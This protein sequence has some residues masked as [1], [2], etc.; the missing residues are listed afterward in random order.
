MVSSPYLTQG[1]P[2]GDGLAWVGKH[3][4]PM[5]STQTL[6]LRACPTHTDHL[7]VSNSGEKYSNI[8]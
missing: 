6:S 4:I 3:L 8:V 1:V 5:V 7:I 2:V